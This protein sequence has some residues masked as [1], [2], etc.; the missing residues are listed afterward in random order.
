M[1]HEEREEDQPEPL[2]GEER[3]NI[4]ADLQDLRSMRGVFEPQG[5]KGVVVACPDC[6]E[7]HYYGW[8][9]L[10]ESLQHMLTTGEPRMH[11]PAYQPKEEEYVLWDYGK[12]YVDALA[13]AGLENGRPVD[14]GTCPWCGS[15]LGKQYSFCPK[16]GRPTAP[17][18]LLGELVAR[19][20]NEREAR[21]LLVK[22]GFEPF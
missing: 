8:E 3:R 16:C 15:T 17:A 14:L 2:E 10:Q 13:D 1:E 4:E 11:E 6:G 21:A 20:M 18:R 12:G 22:A 9:L 5:V 7:D 19:G